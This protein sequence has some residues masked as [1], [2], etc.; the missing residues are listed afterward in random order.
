MVQNLLEISSPISHFL[1]SGNSPSKWLALNRRPQTFRFGPHHF[2]T[3]VQTIFGHRP[4]NSNKITQM[5]SVLKKSQKSS[6][7]GLESD[8]TVP[9]SYRAYTHGCQKLLHNGG[10][11]H[12]PAMQLLPSHSTPSLSGLWILGYCAFYYFILNFIQHKGSIQGT[13]RLM[14]PEL[15]I[16]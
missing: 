14:T 9:S 11:K 10:T 2:S 6:C 13:Y 4:L 8:L 1:E 7:S 3:R 5:T 16:R 12:A 15:R